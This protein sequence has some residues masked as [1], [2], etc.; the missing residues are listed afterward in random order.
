MMTDPTLR[1]YFLGGLAE[2][3][4]QRLE[5]KALEDD[6]LFTTMRSAEDDLFDDYARHRLSKDEEAAFARRF[7]QQ[8]ERIRFARTL[9]ARRDNVLTFRR[10]LTLAAAAVVGAVVLSALFIMQPAPRPSDVLPRPP[11]SVSAV[12]MVEIRL[13][14][15]RNAETQPAIT[16]RNGVSTLHLRVHLDPGDRFEHYAMEL[17][18]AGGIAWSARG[19]APIVRE[20]DL[21]LSA[22][23]PAS[24]LAGG[25]YELSVRG[26]EELLGVTTLEI[27]RTD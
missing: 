9:A 15:S 22:A 16:L 7:G 3:E 21:F 17:R 26:G 19:L 4:A 5:E 2:E 8:H 24:A 14:T 20:G 11:V 23:V 13:G 18:S 10:R 27:R 1:A 6:Q 12:E 25:P